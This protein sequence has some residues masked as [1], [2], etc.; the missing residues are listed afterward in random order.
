MLENNS[1]QAHTVRAGAAHRVAQRNGQQAQMAIALGE[2]LCAQ[3]V[4]RVEETRE[5][6][7]DLMQLVQGPRATLWKA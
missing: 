1:L 5:M 2:I 7:A 4:S 3:I 6:R